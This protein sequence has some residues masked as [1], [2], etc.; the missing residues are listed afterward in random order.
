MRHIS[1]ITRMSLAVVLLAACGTEPVAP[2]ADIAVALAPTS[3]GDGQTGTVGTPLPS[4]LRVL[5]TNNNLPE[6]GVTV[7]WAAS[8]GEGVV[9]PS[10]ATTDGNGIAIAIWT[11]PT[12]SGSLSATATVDG[13]EGSPVTFT[14]DAVAGPPTTFDIRANDNQTIPPGATTSEPLLVGLT[15]TY[16]NP[17][18][19]ST[20]NWSV[21]SGMATL[22]ALSVDTGPN[23]TA[24]VYVT[25]GPTPGPVVV[26]A[27]SSQPFPAVDF[28]VT[29]TP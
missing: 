20:V 22:S 1:V 13:A 26:R 2:P 9:A 21:F 6:S 14:A 28:N 7:N 27:I 24:G 18:V 23:G 16:G 15:D 12:T 25:A 19:G 8:P 4:N 10:V 17:V 5:V 29:I 3:S 11:L